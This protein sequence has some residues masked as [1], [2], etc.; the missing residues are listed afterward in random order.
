M[1]EAWKRE[2]KKTIRTVGAKQGDSTPRRS[3]III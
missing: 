1:R 2:E 3:K